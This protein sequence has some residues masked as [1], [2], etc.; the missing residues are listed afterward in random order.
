VFFFQI[1]YS[2]LISR[3]SSTSIPSSSSRPPIFHAS[4]KLLC[5]SVGRGR[6]ARCRWI[7]STLLLALL[8]V[9]VGTLNKR[10]VLLGPR[11]GGLHALVQRHTKF[12]CRHTNTGSSVKLCGVYVCTY[13]LLLKAW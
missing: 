1:L 11:L 13:D 7:L 2:S 12:K 4:R 5:G 9:Y 10:C 8:R 6:T 3:S